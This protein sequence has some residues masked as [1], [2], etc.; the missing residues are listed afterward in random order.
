[1]ERECFV[2][3]KTFPNLAIVQLHLI[4]FMGNEHI[5]YKTGVMYTN[6]SYTT[7]IQTNQPSYHHD[8]TVL[9][10]YLCFIFKEILFPGSRMRTVYVIF[11]C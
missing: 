6:T 10:P 3:S 11:I 8:L 1:M 9:R 7:G 5:G 2:K 4:L